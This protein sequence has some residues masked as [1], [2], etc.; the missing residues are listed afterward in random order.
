[1]TKLKG[2]NSKVGGDYSKYVGLGNVQ[3]LACN[4]NKEQLEEIL[5][6]T[7]EKEPDYTSKPDQN[8]VNVKPLILW[9]KSESGAVMSAF[10]GLSKTPIT[11]KN[12]DKFKFINGKG[13]ISYYAATAEEIAN[14][15]KVNKW[16]SPNGMRKLM[17]GE[18]TLYNLLQAFN[19]YNASE[20]GANWMEV[21]TEMHINAED[22]ESKGLNEFIDYLNN[23]NNSLIMSHVIQVKEDE[24]GKVITRQQLLLDE[25]TYFRTEDGQV[26]DYMID[27]LKKYSDDKDNEGYSV[28]KKEFFVGRLRKFDTSEVP[29]GVAEEASETGGKSGLLDI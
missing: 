6:T 15:P 5:G 26:K 2:G 23:G 27:K 25:N 21:M 22:F 18:D 8:G 20:E 3:L 14:N 10:I 24:D 7:L 17:V 19:R 12:G 29:A 16:Y 13:Q 4:P 9:F 11:T 1:M 28:T